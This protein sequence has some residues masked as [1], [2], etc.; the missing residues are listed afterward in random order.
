MGWERHAHAS[1]FTASAQLHCIHLDLKRAGCALHHLWHG[2]GRR[3]LAL[4]ALGLGQCHGH[5]HAHCGNAG[6][7]G[8]AR[9]TGISHKIRAGLSRT[10][11]RKASARSASQSSIQAAAPTWVAQARSRQ[12]LHC[13]CLSCAEQPCSSG[14]PAGGKVVW[15]LQTLDRLQK[16]CRLAGT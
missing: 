4:G 9:Q 6:G 2:A 10:E 1:R 7:K 5:V 16:L 15:A 13:L 12:R 11:L 8:G 3:F 14:Q